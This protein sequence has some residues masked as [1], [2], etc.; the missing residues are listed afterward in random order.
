MQ[1]AKRSP[2]L[3]ALF[4]PASLSMLALTAAAGLCAAWWMAPVGLFLWLIIFIVAYRDPALKLGNTVAGRATLA[5]RFQDKFER[6]QKT[7]TSLFITLGSAPAKAQ[8]LLNPIQQAV[9]ELVEQTYQVCLRYANVDNYI[10][11]TRANKNF[12]DEI[13]ALEGKLVAATDEHV[14]KEYEE[15]LH[16]LRAQAD[17]V[18]RMINLLERF[19][20]QLTTL[21]SSLESIH[22]EAVRLQTVDEQTIRTTIPDLLRQI[23]AQSQELKGF[24]RQA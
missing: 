18:Q 5:Y 4:H 12:S 22:A 11:V 15:A 14:R 17:N 9:N 6:V 2:F 16:T 23:E 7:Q 24:E 13:E 19:E 21:T 1:N 8:R 20:T 10:A 3:T